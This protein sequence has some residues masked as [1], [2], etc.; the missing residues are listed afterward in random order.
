MLIRKEDGAAFYVWCPSEWSNSFF[1][2]GNSL[3]PPKRPY[4]I[5]VCDYFKEENVWQFVVS[6]PAMMMVRF[7]TSIMHNR[8]SGMARVLYFI[9]R[10]IDLSYSPCGI[11]WRD[12]ITKLSTQ[13]TELQWHKPF[14]LRQTEYC[15]LCELPIILLLHKCS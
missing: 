8:N 1:W 7:A 10:K 14:I 4:S 6:T 15:V 13:S 12:S 3:C 9:N 11:I 5:Y 2:L